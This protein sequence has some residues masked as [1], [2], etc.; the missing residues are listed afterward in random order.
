LT[1]PGETVLV[2]TG[3]DADLA[4]RAGFRVEGDAVAAL[5]AALESRG[6]TSADV[7]TIVHTHLHYDHAQ[8]HDAFPAATVFVQRSELAWACE[9][10][11][12]DFVLGAN[13]LVAALGERLRPL[14]GE[15]VVADGI[16]VLPTGGHTPGHQAVVIDTEQGSVCLAAD[17][18]PLARNRSQPAPNCPDRS[19]VARFLDRAAGAGWP[20]LP[21]HDP[22]LRAALADGRGWRSVAAPVPTTNPEELLS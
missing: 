3:P 7:Q 20:L 18:V 16:G 9:D 4:R 8:N 5:R 22:E 21:G 11:G 15:A 6:R 10:G 19:A 2:D 17:V 1:A 13:E 12:D 14:E